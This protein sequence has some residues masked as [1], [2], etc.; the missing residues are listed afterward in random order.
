[1][2]KENGLDKKEAYIAPD[3]AVVEIEMEQNIFAGSVNGKTNNI[4]D[5][6]GEDW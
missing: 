2:K 5:L 3:I 6:G 1:M 4:S